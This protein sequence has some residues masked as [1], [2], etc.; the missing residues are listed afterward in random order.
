WPIPGKGERIY[1]LAD[2][3]QVTAV[4][5][6][7][8][9]S[10]VSPEMHDR[11]L[12]LDWKLTARAVVESGF[13]NGDYVYEKLTPAQQVIVAEVMGLMGIEELAGR[14]VQ[15]LSTGELRKVLIARALVGRPRVLALDEACDG[16]DTTARH[17]LLLRLQQLAETGTQLLF[18][19]Q[20]RK[21]TRLN[22]SHT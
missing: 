13:R 21:S 19:T 22:S 18:S 14:N 11:Y 4:K 12:Q 9:I 7:E 2:R 1:R 15:E 20:D 10:M 8:Q 5:V 3:P 17:D 16:L 6:K